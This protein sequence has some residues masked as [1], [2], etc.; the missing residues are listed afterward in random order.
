MEDPRPQVIVP[1]ARCPAC[2]AKV[3]P[4]SRCGDCG[5]MAE[6]RQEIG[7]IAGV[8]QNFGTVNN[9][10]NFARPEPEVELVDVQELQDSLNERY[11]ERVRRPEPPAPPQLGPSKAVR[12]V[13]AATYVWLVVVLA[14]MAGAA[15]AVCR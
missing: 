12:L 9:V 1:G 5:R 11:P 13:N 3:R 15:Y 10:Y 8:N 14:G 7:F 2:G 6:V 4:G